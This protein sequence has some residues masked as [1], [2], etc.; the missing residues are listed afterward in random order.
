VEAD[1]FYERVSCETLILRAKHGL[2]SDRDIVMPDE[3]VERMVREIPRA[4]RVDFETNHF[5]LVF[6]PIPERDRA[7]LDFLAAQ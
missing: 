1:R 3:V 7:I 6:D 2:L 4:S 5:I